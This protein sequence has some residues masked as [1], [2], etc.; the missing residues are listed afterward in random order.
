MKLNV[1][2]QKK[3]SKDHTYTPVPGCINGYGVKTKLIVEEQLEVNATQAKC[4]KYELNSADKNK[5]SSL[6]PKNIIVPKN[7]VQSNR[8]DIKMV[9]VKL[10]VTWQKK[11]SKDLT[12]THVPGSVN[13]SCVKK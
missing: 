6:E 3:L 2:P 10:N 5:S 1:T 7:A 8:N 4:T 9:E 11:V 13:G 12:N